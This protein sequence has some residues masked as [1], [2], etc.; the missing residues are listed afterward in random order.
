MPDVRYQ[1]PGVP[2]GPGQGITAFMPHFNRP[3]ASGAAQYKYGLTGG[4]AVAHPIDMR[5]V[6]PSPARGDLAM[7]GYARSADAPDAYWRDD[8]DFVAPRA[9]HPG[10]GMP[11]LTPDNCDT[12]GMRSLIPMPSG[13]TDVLA[14]TGSARLS[15]PALLNRIKQVPWFP[16]QYQAPDA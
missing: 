3:A 11:I 6:P 16:R 4:P 8:Y 13:P 2:A 10:A 15:R 1:T 5:D 12:P 7:T 9:E 14:R